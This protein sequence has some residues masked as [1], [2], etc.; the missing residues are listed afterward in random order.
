MFIRFRFKGIL[1][2][3]GNSSIN[4]NGIAQGLGLA[5]VKNIYLQTHSKTLLMID[6]RTI[7][8]KVNCME[9]SKCDA[10]KLGMLWGINVD[11]GIIEPATDAVDT[12]NT[13]F[14]AAGASG[15]VNPNYIGK[16]SAY[17]PVPFTCFSGIR[18]FYSSFLEQ[19]ELLVETNSISKVWKNRVVADV[20]TLDGVDLM[21]EYL[22]M[23]DS[24]YRTILNKQ[25]SSSAP[26]SLLWHSYEKLGKSTK[27]P[28]AFDVQVA[29]AS[30]HQD[31]EFIITTTS[32]CSVTKLYIRVFHE[33]GTKGTF[34]TA[35]PPVLTHPETQG[36]I[37]HNNCRISSV[38]LE[39]G[40]RV[41]VGALSGLEA[42]L[43]E[44]STGCGHNRLLAT[45]NE[46]TDSKF[47]RSNTWVY[48]FAL[49]GDETYSSGFASFAGLSSQT[50]TIKAK[51]I[52]DSP[53]TCEIWAEKIQ[54]ISCYGADGRV[55][56]ALSS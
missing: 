44:S 13:R 35:T 12:Y 21:T 25:Y 42:L 54:V 10:Y 7:L 20:P 16:L 31:V 6:R 8:D 2:K 1:N 33:A 28:V 22:T 5:M 40:G 37:D 24:E 4:A 23:S 29:G 14:Y 51:P 27:S 18:G 49:S 48:S 45:A 15:A 38:T 32:V 30:A 55:T 50:F 17:C 56:T 46:I 43:V 19:M 41:I 36:L 52:Y 53:M 9:K 11:D 39:C 34:N 26:T 3:T 47:G